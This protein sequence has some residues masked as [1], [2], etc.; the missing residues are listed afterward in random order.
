MR[1]IQFRLQ[2]EDYNVKYIFTRFYNK[3]MERSPTTPQCI[4]F[5]PR[6]LTFMNWNFDIQGFVI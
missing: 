1:E 3:G 4:S 6:L 5:I 2:G